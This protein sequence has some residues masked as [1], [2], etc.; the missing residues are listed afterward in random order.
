VGTIE[1]TERIHPIRTQCEPDVP[2]LFTKLQELG[3]E[4]LSLLAIEGVSQLA[5]VLLAFC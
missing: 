2:R 5:I 4:M 1:V 3:V